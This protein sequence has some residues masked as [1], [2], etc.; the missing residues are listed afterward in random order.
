MAYKNIIITIMLFAVGCSILFTS[1]LQLDDL[2]KSRKDL[3]L[4]A[5]KPLENAPPALAFATV[6]M[7][8]FR[9][10]VVDILWMRADSLKEEG[11]FFDAKQLA[12]WITVLQPRFSAVWDFQSW[13]M[14]YNISVAM[15]PSQPEERWKW[16]RNGYE[17]LRDKGIPRN[18]NSIILYRSLAWI[19]QHKIS[20]VTDDVHKYYKIQL[21]LSMRPLISPL[22]N[23]HFE[24]LSNAPETL[25][26]LTESDESA[27]ELVSKMREFAPDV[28]SEELTDLEFAGVF[29]ALLDSAGEGYP[30]QLVEFVRAEIES[31]RFEK[32]RNFCQACKLRQEWKF[33][34][35][36]M[37]KVNKRYGP[38]DLKTGDRLPLNWEHPD[39]HA[40]FWAEKGLETAGREG[41]Y[42]TDELNTDRIVFHSLKNLYRMG[43][44][45]IY[46]VPLKLPRSD[47]DKQRGNLD[48]PQ[49]EPEYKVG[50]T[51]YMLPDLRMFDAYNQ[52][53]LD[54]IEKYRE[55][56][57]ANLR[58]LKNGH[59]NI[60]N[61]AIFTL[62]MA[63]HRK[64]AAE[65][66][67]QLKELYPRDENDMALK[68]FCRNRMEEELDGLTITDAR[69]MVTMMLKESY[70]RFAV[71]DDDMSS[72]REKMARSVADYYKRTSGTEDVDRAM[73]ADFPKLRYMALMDFLNDG[74]YPDNLKQSLL[75]RIKNN[76]PDIYEKLTA[77]REKVQKEAPPEGKL[78]NE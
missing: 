44:Y 42:S 34:I 38:V 77:E 20:G 3:D 65:A 37:K 71:G 55:F 8:A 45:V 64:K 5:N 15:P 61:D 4:V 35:D 51:L 11:K 18:P 21:A 63:G 33:D 24:K 30:D 69:E 75:A 27:A 66:F 78:K 7:G 19:F 26:Q 74:K 28:F 62:Y 47:T 72:A 36:L 56:E 6:A 1:S 48:K 58:P 54:R 10:L 29:F 52:A 16:V 46:N 53:H 14:A 31:Q 12:E 68:Q 22:T 23:E 76:R 2:N 17:L 13:N 57:E 59:R 25:S 32:L 73:L 39:A 43:K 9:G 49:D 50:K 67:K 70:F 40:I 60:L 41:D